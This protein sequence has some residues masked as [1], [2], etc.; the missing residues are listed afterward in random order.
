MG[1]IAA[2]WAGARRHGQARGGMEGSAAARTYLAKTR[3]RADMPRKSPQSAG[4]PPQRKR[5]ERAPSF[6]C[7]WM[8]PVSR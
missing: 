8:M 7:V 1:G 6:F 2:A 5:T 4:L 3:I